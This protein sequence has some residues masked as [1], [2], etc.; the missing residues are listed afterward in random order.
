MI[1]SPKKSCLLFLTVGAYWMV[2]RFFCSSNVSG[3]LLIVVMY[4]Y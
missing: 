1:P 4:I 2:S 3:S